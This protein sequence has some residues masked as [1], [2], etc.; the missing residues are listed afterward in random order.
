MSNS[1]VHST[2]VRLRQTDSDSLSNY[3]TNPPPGK[4][5]LLYGHP[6]IFRLSLAIASHALL[7]STPIGVVDG[8]NRFDVHYLSHFARER[9][10][11]PKVLLDNIYISRGFTCYQMEAVIKDRLPEFL[12]KIDSHTALIFGLLD[13]FYDEQAPL[14]EVKQIL[15]CVIASLQEMKTNGISILLTS[16]EWNVFPKER[17]QLFATLKA[18]V[19]RVYRLEASE[20]EEPKLFLEQPLRRITHGTN[21]TNL[22]P[23]HRQ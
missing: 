17:N 18:S 10:V 20:H 23:N 5:Y 4:V 9:C 12:K 22:Y 7:S 21:R 8:A 6:A 3:F 11:N 15:Q 16:T 2:A 19:D 13:T 14:F 1:V